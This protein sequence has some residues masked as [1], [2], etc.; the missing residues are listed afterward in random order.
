[1]LDKRISRSSPA[2]PRGHSLLC[3]H[4][5]LD[6]EPTIRDLRGLDPMSHGRLSRRRSNSSISC[7]WYDLAREINTYWRRE[8]T[9]K[10]W[11]R[12][13]AAHDVATSL[14]A[15]FLLVAG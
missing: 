9:R 2:F 10:L 11:R 5:P 12:R 4:S 7:R 8:P 13:I 3:E 14:M 1:M 6:H 15:R